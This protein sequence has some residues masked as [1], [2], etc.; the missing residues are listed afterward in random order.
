VIVKM[1]CSNETYSEVLVG[2]YTCIVSYLSDNFPILIHQE[3]PM[4]FNF[5]VEYA[6]HLEGQRKAA[7]TGID[8]NVTVSDRC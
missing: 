3:Q 4:L 7:V 6:Y 1:M 2:R 5:T 8:L